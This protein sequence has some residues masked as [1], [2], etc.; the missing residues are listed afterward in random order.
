M[1]DPSARH[2]FHKWQEEWYKAS[3]LERTVV[4]MVKTVENQ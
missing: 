3:N 2:E 4:W 1:K